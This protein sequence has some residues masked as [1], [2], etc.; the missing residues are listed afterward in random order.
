MTKGKTGYRFPHLIQWR[1]YVDYTRRARGMESW[2]QISKGHLVLCHEVVYNHLPLLK[3]RQCGRK[4]VRCQKQIKCFLSPGF[5][6]H[7]KPT[8][9]SQQLG[10][11]SVGLMKFMTAWGRALAMTKMHAYLRTW[12][13]TCGYEG[14]AK[15]SVELPW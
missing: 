12:K 8:Q 1:E 10:R 6:G 9:R 4:E 11:L 7:L 3:G 5:S 14:V 13:I 2:E 15:H